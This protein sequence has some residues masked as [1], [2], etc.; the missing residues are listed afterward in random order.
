MSDDDND[1][2][3]MSYVWPPPRTIHQIGPNVPLHALCVITTFP[4]SLKA[5]SE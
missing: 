4:A 1:N 2:D 5:I 3:D